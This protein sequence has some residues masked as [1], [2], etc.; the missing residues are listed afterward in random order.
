MVFFSGMTM[1]KGQDL[2]N[3]AST[4]VSVCCHMMAQ[5]GFAGCGI[6]RQSGWFPFIVRAAL[7][8][9][10][11][12]FSILLYSHEKSS[13]AMIHAYHSMVFA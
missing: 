3:L 6:N 1:W 10:G 11:T 13:E 7:I 8:A 2:T 4:I 12:C 5:V 9:F